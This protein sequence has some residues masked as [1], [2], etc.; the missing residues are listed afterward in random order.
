MKAQTNES[1][2]KLKLIITTAIIFLLTMSAAAA[3]A[4][5]VRQPD[6]LGE[7]DNIVLSEG[8][9]DTFGHMLS[10]PTHPDAQ[11]GSVFT[12]TLHLPE[13]TD[14]LRAPVLYFTARYLNARFYLDGELLGES[15]AQPAGAEDTQ[16]TVFTL[17]PLPEDHAGA[18]LRIDVDLL[19][20][21]NVSYEV[22]APILGSQCSIIA[23]IWRRN[24]LSV[25]VDIFIFCFGIILLLFGLQKGSMGRERTFLFTGLFALCFSLYSLC[26]SD[27][28]HLLCRNAYLIY[29][30]EFLLLAV[31]PIPLAAAFAERCRPPYRQLLQA[32]LALLIVNLIFQ[33]AAH[34]FTPLEVRDTVFLTHGMMLLSLGVMVPS[35]LLGWDGERRWWTVITFS[36]ILLGAL[37][38]LALFYG[39]KYFRDSFWVKIGVLVFILLQ[40]YTL[41]KDYL[42]HYENDLKADVYRR[43]AYVDALTGLGNRAAFE[44]KIIEL[45]RTLPQLTALWCVSADVNG[46]KQV[47]DTLGHAAGDMLIRGAAEVLR[48]AHCPCCTI[49]RTGGDEFVLFITNQPEEVVLQSMIRVSEAIAAYE[50]SHGQ[51]LSIALGWDGF[52]FDGADTV[53]ELVSR[54]DG[55]MYAKKRQWKEQHTSE[56][57]EGSL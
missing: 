18:E 11:S 36:P 2:G 30:F 13:D 32:D 40:T 52:Q 47:N 28:L 26:T 10:F 5:G 31:L 25:L 21:E 49:F 29:L 4:I 56:E 44:Q 24:G 46:L 34:F 35:L 20:G 55:Q 38:D 22:P 57:K 17:L 1:C 37:V 41:V 39:T 9:T 8:W 43:M 54:A 48:S 51:A 33:A 53:G 45:E 23:A 27:M 3:A 14:A 16:G 42:E 15:L 50:K 7:D 12:Y 19:L 6:L